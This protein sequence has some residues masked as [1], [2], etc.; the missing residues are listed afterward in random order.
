MLAPLYSL[1][2]SCTGIANAKE[3]AKDL[4]S[5]SS[6]GLKHKVAPGKFAYIQA[7]TLWS[8]E[9]RQHLRPGHGWVCELGDAGDDKGCFEKTYSSSVARSWTDYEGVRLQGGESA[10]KVER[11]F[12]RTPD[13]ASGCTFVEWDPKKDGA[14]AGPHILLYTDVH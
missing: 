6:R 8:E 2:N 13:D 11:W 9:E 14:A 1:S 3:Y 5:N 12:H 7:D 4:W 10:L